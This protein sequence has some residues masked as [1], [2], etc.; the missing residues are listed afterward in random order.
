MI[1]LS[2]AIRQKRDWHLKLKRD[3]VVNRWKE[4]ATAAQ[5][6]LPIDQM[7]SANMVEYIRSLP[8]LGTHDWLVSDKLCLHRIRSLRQADGY[9]ERNTG[10]SLILCIVACVR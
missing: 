5:Q 3:E 10:S 9:G 2:W 4:E 1:R 7:L 8:L 6:C